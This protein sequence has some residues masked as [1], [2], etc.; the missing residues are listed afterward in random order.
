MLD[1]KFIVGGIVTL[2]LFASWNDPKLY[3]ET[4]FNWINWVFW[5]TLGASCV[6]T[7]A[8]IVVKLQLPSTLDIVAKEAILEAIEKLEIPTRW[9]VYFILLWVIAN[10]SSV[11]AS[12]REKNM[13]E[14]TNS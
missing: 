4:L 7:I 3:R 13:E 5:V 1:E 12:R 8:M 2:L 10:I 6:W 9:L 11:I 14:K